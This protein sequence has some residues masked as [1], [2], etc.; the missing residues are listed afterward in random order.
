MFVDNLAQ[1]PLGVDGIII[2]KIGE[3][4]RY[5]EET[6]DLVARVKRLKDVGLVDVRFEEGLVKD[7]LPTE[8][9][10]VAEVQKAV[11][12]EEPTAE[13]DEADASSTE[14]NSVEE[15]PAAKPKTRGGRGGK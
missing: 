6:E 12:V 10:P 4:N 13:S 3:Q 11:K 7:G 9:E 1:H 15:E 5:I 14:P 2:L 8:A